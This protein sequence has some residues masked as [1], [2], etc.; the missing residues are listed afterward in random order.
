MQETIE[1]LKLLF[2]FLGLQVLKYFKQSLEL[3][4]KFLAVSLLQYL[5]SLYV[6][7]SHYSAKLFLF[8]SGE[9]LL[10]LEKCVLQY[11]PRVLLA[12]QT[13]FSFSYF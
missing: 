2:G 12:F 9:A 13:C 8:R 1:L 11:Y 6:S 7:G 5:H 4:P 10:R 3:S